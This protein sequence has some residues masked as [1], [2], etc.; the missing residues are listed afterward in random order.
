LYVDRGTR[1]QISQYIRTFALRTTLSAMGYSQSLTGA[2]LTSSPS[3]YST[4]SKLLVGLRDLPAQAEGEIEVTSKSLT[5]TS[6]NLTD[7]LTLTRISGVFVGDERAETGGVAGKV[8]RI[9]IPFGG[10]S[11]LGT[12]TQKQVGLLTVDYRDENDGLRSAVFLLPK[13][14]A[15]KIADE[16]EISPVSNSS[17]I[18]SNVCDAHDPSRSIRV[19]PVQSVPGLVVAP[20]YR[21]LLYEKLLELPARD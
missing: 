13:A 8:A 15:L 3:T 16:M 20:E 2:N 18:T 19:L 7:R 21:A 4:E 5:F 17:A 10:G 12:V 9:V 6:S 11:A 1:M 14:E